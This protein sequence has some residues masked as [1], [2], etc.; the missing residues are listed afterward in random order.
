MFTGLIEGTG[1]IIE[2]SGSHLVV[3]AGSPFAAERGDSIA[4]NGCCLTLGRDAA[5][6]ELH[7]FTLSETLARTALGTLP[8]GASV[9][10]ER[11]LAVGSRLDGH[12][13]Q[14]HVDAALK[15]LALG[16]T[17]T[18]DMELRIELP[19]EFAALAVEKGSVAVDGVSL[20]VAKV[21][22]ESFSVCLIPET[23]ERT[24]LRERRA[25][26]RVDVEFDILGKYV[27][28]QLECRAV[29][30]GTLTWEKLSSAGFM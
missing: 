9:N 23:W 27:L 5:G 4:V 21:D 26:S 30:S 25:G 24:A 18:G 16:R 11:A 1:R 7:F 14:G 28:R 15:V 2:R 10:L 17:E 3:R 29:S 22:A 13:V 20:T 12:L 19:Q 6:G 8:V